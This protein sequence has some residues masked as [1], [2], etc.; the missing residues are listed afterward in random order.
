VSRIPASAGESENQTVPQEILVEPADAS[1]NRVAVVIAD[2]DHGRRLG[3]LNSQA[4]ILATL[5]N[6]NLGIVI[7]SRH[8]N[9]TRSP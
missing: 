3:A 5:F 1:E 9:A 2:E 8:E 4:E 6:E 7:A